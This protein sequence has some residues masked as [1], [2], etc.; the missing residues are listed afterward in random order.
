M[1]STALGKR[2]RQHWLTNDSYDPSPIDTAK[3]RRAPLKQT[4]AARSTA[5]P[6]GPSHENEF[7]AAVSGVEPLFPSLNYDKNASTKKFSP[8]RAKKADVENIPPILRTPRHRD[9][10]QKAPITPRHKISVVGKPMTPRSQPGTPS[11]RI[12]GDSVASVLGA[13]RAMFARGSAPGKLIGRE[14]EREKLATYLGERI[15][16][17]EGGCLYIS[18]PPG[19]GKSALL[20]ETL[21]G[22]ERNGAAGVKKTYVNCMVVKDPKGIY[23]RLLEEFWDADVM[24]DVESKDG[25]DELERLFVSPQQGKRG[26]YVV[27]LDEI[28]H[29]LTKDQEILYSIF[30]WSL[31]KNSNLI[32]IGIANALDLTDKFLPRLKARNLKPQLLPFQP[33]DAKQIAEVITSRLRSLLPEDAKDKYYVPYVHPAAIQLCARKVAAH[34]GDLRKAFDMCRR[35]LELLDSELKEKARKEAAAK[36]FTSSEEYSSSVGM[37]PLA[38]AIERLP[39]GEARLNHNLPNTSRRSASPTPIPQTPSKT[40]ITI[41]Y[42][43]LTGPRVTIAHIARISSTTFGG[44]ALSRVKCLNL[45]QKAVLCACCVHE[46]RKGQ[47]PTMRELYASYGGVC[48]RDRLLARLSMVEFRDVVG[49]LESAG[50]VGLSTVGAVGQRTPSKKNG[51]AGGMDE[52]RVSCLVREGE[53]R[54]E[55]EWVGAL[56]R[57]FME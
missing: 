46:T 56:G 51:G 34:T 20:N 1:A 36:A 26:V 15:E 38:V 43:P 9:A 39:L 28:D 44:S 10:I 50:V 16:G 52:R 31:A 32:L 12:Q 19:T 57:M 25:M 48:K 47:A 37:T 33:Y 8:L 40:K 35:G 30:E 17:G 21:E 7:E 24:G 2:A 49:G 54:K 3:A 13:A 41:S 11:S 22:V 5:T 53:L 23:A 4:R 6:L 29:L 42:D 18:G 55:V 27:V 45:Q 14:R